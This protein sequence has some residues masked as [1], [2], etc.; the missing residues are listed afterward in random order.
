MFLA[1]IKVFDREGEVIFLRTNAFT[2]MGDIYVWM[3]EI[4][5][6]FLDGAT[7]ILLDIA[8]P[9]GEGKE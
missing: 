2:S 5:R 9:Y 6:D 8:L 1:Q 4:R 7:R 3:E